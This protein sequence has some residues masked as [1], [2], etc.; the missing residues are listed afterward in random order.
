VVASAAVTNGGETAVLIELARARAGSWQQR[1]KKHRA[2]KT[3]HQQAK[4]TPMPELQKASPFADT[5]NWLETPLGQILLTQES[6]L[7]EEVLDGLFGEESLQLGLWGDPKTFL[8]FS[9]TQRSASIANPLNVLHD[10]SPSAYGR[11]HRLPIASDSV[12]VVILPHTL[13]FS[14]R[15]HEILREVHRVLRSDGQLVILGFKPGG[16]WGLRRLVPGAGLPPHMHHPIGDR[17]LSDWL[18][19][20]DLRIHGLTRYFFRW[21]LTGSRASQSALWEERGRRWWPEF[22]ACYMLTAQKRVFTLTPVK[23]PWRARPKV[24]G[25]LAEP[26]TRVSRIRFDENS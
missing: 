18:K 1:P 20:L 14:S 19:L 22:A 6:R 9:R 5:R 10:E 26:T 3:C 2:R 4:E 21:P 25:G 16:L 11:M 8:R 17:Q 23:Q 12:D 7:V 24:V 15:P 13:D